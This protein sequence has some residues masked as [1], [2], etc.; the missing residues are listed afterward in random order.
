MA[1]FSS[2]YTLPK[3]YFQ[4]LS[5]IFHPFSV[6]LFSRPIFLLRNF[7]PPFPPLLYDFLKKKSF[8]SHANG[9]NHLFFLPAK[10][11]L[12]ILTRRRLDR[13]RN[14]LHICASLIPFPLD[15]I[16]QQMKVIQP[17]VKHI[18]FGSFSSPL[19]LHKETFSGPRSTECTKL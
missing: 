9:R 2:F 3:L 17:F 15:W 11:V 7:L 18:K 16:L 10:D 13:R 1:S 5:N 4:K 6:L 14:N 12:S 8:R 19:H